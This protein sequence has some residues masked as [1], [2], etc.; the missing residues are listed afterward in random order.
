[1]RTTPATSSS[2]VTIGAKVD[3]SDIFKKIDQVRGGMREELEPPLLAQLFSK[4]KREHARM[5]AQT[6]AESIR[7]RKELIQ[8]LADAVKIYVDVHKG[9]LKVRGYA[10]VMATFEE[11]R[12]NLLTIAEATHNAT[13]VN[14]S[15][16]YTK[17]M[18]IPNLTDAQRKDQLRRAWKRMTAMQ[19]HAEETF[20]EVLEAMAAMVREVSD[21]IGRPS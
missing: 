6:N 19:N 8:G 14:Y 9:D 4:D 12:M 7:A 17:V 16:T 11:M 10:H 3:P 21:E 1:M 2:S 15:N 5:I 20:L 13:A 18:A